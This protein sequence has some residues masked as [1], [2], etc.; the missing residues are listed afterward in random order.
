MKTI[1]ALIPLAVLVASTTVSFAQTPDNPPT[2][3]QQDPAPVPTPGV[4]T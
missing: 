2:P 1:R 3:A 4:H